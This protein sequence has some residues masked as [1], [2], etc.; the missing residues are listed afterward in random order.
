MSFNTLNFR[1]S[2]GP[3]PTQKPS[4]NPRA[5]EDANVVNL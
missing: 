4:F 2:K 5:K 1:A 3:S